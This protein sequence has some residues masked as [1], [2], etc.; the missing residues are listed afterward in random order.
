VRAQL[1][2]HAKRAGTALFIIGH[3]TN[4]GAIAGPRVLEAHRRH[5]AVLG[6]IPHS[7]ASG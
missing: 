5:G 6:A 4:G 3:V 2:R 7:Q 1:T